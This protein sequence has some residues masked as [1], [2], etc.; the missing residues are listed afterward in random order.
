M[1]NLCCSSKLYFVNTADADKERKEFSLRMKIRRLRCQVN[2]M[3]RFKSKIN[4]ID[5]E[6]CRTI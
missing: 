4:P 3:R 1:K 2:E 6:K 5:L